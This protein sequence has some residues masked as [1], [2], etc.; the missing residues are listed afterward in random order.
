MKHNSLK[1][2]GILAVL[3]I[4]LQSLTAQDTAR[5]LG[6]KEAIDLSI[7][8][9]KQ[10]KNSQAKIEEA[11]A[12]LKEA[13]QKRLPDAGVG[14][15]YM[16]VTQPDINLKVKSNSSGGSG[17]SGSGINLSAIKISQ[18]MYGSL[19]VSLPLY[20]GLK[21]K[22]GIESATY[23]EQAA[24]LDA[25]HDQEEIIQNAINL[26][27]NLYKAKASVG[28]VQESLSQSRQRVTDFSNL[29]K[30][31][32]LAR[33]DLLKAELETSNI[34]LSL[35]DAQNNWKLANVSMNLM[36]G[37][38][39]KTELIPDSASLQGVGEVKNL[40]EYEQLALQNRKDMQSLAFHKKAA[41]AGITTAK[42][43]YYPSLALTAGYIALDIPNFISVTNAFTIGAGLKYNLASLWKT[44]AKVEQARAR[45]RQLQA[46]EELLNDNIRMEI[47]Q[48]YE[49]YMLSRKKIDVYAEAIDQATENYKI[50]KNKYDN[51]LVTTTDLLDADVASLQAKLNF[52]YAK[53]DAVVAYNK[54][55]QSA[56]LL[57]NPTEK[58]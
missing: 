13:V 23:L 48:A 30:N 9:S 56:G 34:A 24:K 52:A 15:T 38:P 18:A 37:L 12:A 27:A 5:N 20:T 55:L 4:N 35:L 2:V 1:A 19:N 40:D 21:I 33:N 32:L 45:E 28:L 57:D 39:E 41:T 51:S 7:K 29:E 10:L 17:G 3:L 50:T 43:D 25:E 42:A 53:A 49:N 54:L 16:Y 11:T 47:N 22:S 44:D 31:G 26:F 6:L 36:M 58:K 8:N 46:N 14:G